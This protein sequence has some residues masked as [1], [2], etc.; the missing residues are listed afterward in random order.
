MLS[1]LSLFSF[2]DKNPLWAMQHLCSVSTNQTKNLLP[3]VFSLL[4]SDICYTNHRSLYSPAHCSGVKYFLKSMRVFSSSPL[5]IASLPRRLVASSSRLLLFSSPLC[6][7][8]SSHRRLV[9][10]SSRLL[11]FSS[12]CPLIASSHSEDFPI[13]SLPI[14]L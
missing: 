3:L 12:P 10:S 4:G 5:L 11:L 7:F 6:L 1:V 8:A 2:W 13:C 14:W 9:A